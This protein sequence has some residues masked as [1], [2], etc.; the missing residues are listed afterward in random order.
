LGENSV[1]CIRFGRELRKER[2][3]EA[4]TVLLLD[5]PKVEIIIGHRGQSSST[6]VFYVVNNC[7]TNPIDEWI[8][9]MKLWKYNV[10]ERAFSATRYKIREPSV[11]DDV[12]EVTETYVS[13][14]SIIMTLSISNL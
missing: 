14:E 2:V 4:I 7:R 12:L 5:I 13:H 8:Q 10:H 9:R 11:L 3:E 1:A 6:Q